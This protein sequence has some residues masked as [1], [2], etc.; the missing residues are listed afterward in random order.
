MVLRSL[1]PLLPL[2]GLCLIGSSL[3]A[4]PSTKTIE[5]RWKAVTSAQNSGQYLKAAE[6]AREAIQHLEAMAPLNK[7]DWLQKAARTHI[8]AGL[9]DKALELT[10]Q[11]KGAMGDE[12][13]SN[14]NALYLLGELEANVLELLGRG[15]EAA[16][17]YEWLLGKIRAQEP[18]PESALEV[19]LLRLWRIRREAG[20]GG[21]TPIANE[22]QALN[23]RG[24]LARRLELESTSHGDLW[25]MP[26]KGFSVL[27]SR[28][29][30]PVS[31]A[32]STIQRLEDGLFRVRLSHGLYGVIDRDLKWR[33]RP[34]YLSL[35]YTK[36]TPG[37]FAYSRQT[38]NGKRYGI[39]NRQ[40]QRVHDV[41]STKFLSGSLAPETWHISTA[42]GKT[43]EE[44][45]NPLGG[46]ASQADLLKKNATKH[47]AYAP[48]RKEIRGKFQS[49]VDPSGK[50][51]WTT[52][53]EDEVIHSVT[54]GRYIKTSLRVVTKGNR[55]KRS[56]RTDHGIYDLMTKSWV[57]P[58]SEG[59]TSI[60]FF[61]NGLAPA[62]KKVGGLRMTGLLRPDGT[63][64]LEP[65]FS[66]ISPSAK[67][68]NGYFPAQKQALKYRH[69]RLDG[70]P[71]YQEIFSNVGVFDRGLA[72]ADKSHLV[73]NA[74]KWKPNRVPS[75]IDLEGKPLWP[76]GRVRMLGSELS[77]YMPEP[78]KLYN[79]DLG[80]MHLFKP[81][82]GS[83]VSTGYDSDAH[84]M[85]FLNGR[86]SLSGSDDAESMVR[87]FL[88]NQ[89]KDFSFE[90][91]KDETYR[92]R[93]WSYFRIKGNN[94]ATT[95]GANSGFVGQH[96]SLT[97]IYTVVLIGVKHQDAYLA[98]RFD[99]IL[100]DIRFPGEEDF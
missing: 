46:R 55:W 58:Y 28:Q 73:V 61:S 51:V 23:P 3:A 47:G 33:I 38:L 29:G 31:D 19:Q 12:F 17:V 36:G 62:Q 20:L 8:R 63:W 53:T 21:L 68:E 90:K 96:M 77:L 7:A 100:R 95:R 43:R 99:E 67:F 70:S 84:L 18:V 69:Y 88:N 65:S 39:L 30:K 24:R 66:W 86:K 97:R 22:I 71:L 87:N 32:F 49:L 76:F 25:E 9:T 60:G 40:G 41:E 59:L 82:N 42:D 35:T 85:V 34:A 89:L 11:A 10:R 94:Y 37:F 15:K 4:E 81:K 26:L 78:W 57:V 56:T 72:R 50:T 52:P 91:T 27:V 6:K 16:Q 80:K 98:E 13:E 2:L 75:L 14:F 83:Y 93:K 54:D 1:P 48:F 45:R 44:I 74:W 92:N 79:Y 5:Q 64:A